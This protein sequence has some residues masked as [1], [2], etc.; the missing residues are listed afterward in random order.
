MTGTR[1]LS[2]PAAPQ[3]PDDFSDLIALAGPPALDERY[4]D[5]P[6]ALPTTPGN[7]GL[8]VAPRDPLVSMTELDPRDPPVSMTGLD[9]ADPLAQLTAEYER[10]L[11]HDTSGPQRELR[12]DVVER[13]PSPQPPRDPFEDAQLA[14]SNQSLVDLLVGDENI[15]TIL[16]SLDPY[17]AERIFALDAQHEI[18]SLFAAQQPVVPRAVPSAQLA[19][20]EH[21]LIGVDS[22]IDVLAIASDEP[23]ATP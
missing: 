17:G 13:T 8:G 22:H 10:A 16:D 4:H 19:R 9:D 6:C 23:S 21:H 5:Y 7:R 14:P 1:E 20:E 11:L 2:E 15:D 18:L 12:A 3:A